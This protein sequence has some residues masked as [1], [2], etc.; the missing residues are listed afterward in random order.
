MKKLPIQQ[1]VN[2]NIKQNKDQKDKQIDSAN[3]IFQNLREKRF[4]VGSFIRH[5]EVGQ[6]VLGQ[7]VNED[8]QPLVPHLG[9]LLVEVE[10]H[11]VYALQVVAAIEE[12]TELAL[13]ATLGLL[14]VDEV[15][16]HLF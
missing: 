1:N 2:K 13:Q 3:K 4:G 6:V 7:L 9:T 16:G 12:L 14:L 10:G 11:V 8:G 5:V 15:Y